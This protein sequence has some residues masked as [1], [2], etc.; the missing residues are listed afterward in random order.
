MHINAFFPP[1]PSKAFDRFLDAAFFILYGI[2]RNDVEY[3]LSTFS[4]INNE[5]QTL[6]GSNSTPAKILSFYDNFF[7]NSKK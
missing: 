2:Q 3:V 4:G 1:Y 5:G 7:E 6:L